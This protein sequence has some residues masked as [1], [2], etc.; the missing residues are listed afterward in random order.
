MTSQ[1]IKEIFAVVW[2]WIISLIVV[3]IKAKRVHVAEVYT[4][5][6]WFVLDWYT[7]HVAQVYTATVWFVFDWYSVHVAEVY[8]ATVWFISTEISQLVNDYSWHFDN[9]I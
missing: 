2:I 8:T 9:L 5:A 4:T 3:D 6:A 1:E 7:V